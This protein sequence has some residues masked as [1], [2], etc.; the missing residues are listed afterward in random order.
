M[1]HNF[2]IAFHGGSS[3]RNIFGMFNVPARIYPVVL[4]IL[5]QVLIP[6]ISFLGHLSGI[7]I[8]I[9]ISIG[10][11]N[12]LLPSQE[13]LQKIESYSLLARLVNQSNYVRVNNK[14]F[15]ATN[16]SGMSM[17]STIYLGIVFAITHLCNLLGL[18]GHIIGCPVEHI[19][20]SCSR[21]WL[22]IRSN[23]ENIIARI[24]EFFSQLFTT[25]NN[26]PVNTNEYT[27]LSTTE[28]IQ[29]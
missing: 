26:I 24:Y 2:L 16:S 11:V 9:L 7:L 17:G 29:V 6:G 20:T 19:S 13:S 27:Q 4:L 3:T 8:G 14:T 23:I 12:L 10:G 5:L 28:S 21:F 25:R 1:I 18:I 15:V 22:G